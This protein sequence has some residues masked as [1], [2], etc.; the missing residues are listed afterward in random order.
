[1]KRAEVDP[2]VAAA[3]PALCDANDKQ[4][5]WELSVMYHVVT[6]RRF[7]APS[8]ARAG[9]IF[10]VCY[11]GGHVRARI[12]YIRNIIRCSELR[13]AGDRTIKIGEEEPSMEFPPHSRQMIY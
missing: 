13:F 11:S 3:C 6:H 2:R 4:S 8:F 5:L 1:M 10:V 7:I 12:S 9:L